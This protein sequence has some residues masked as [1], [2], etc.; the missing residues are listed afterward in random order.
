[1]SNSER[2]HPLVLQAQDKLAA[3]RIDR[4]E[5]LRYATLL[6]TSLTAA[7]VLAACGQPAAAPAAAPATEPAAAAADAPAAAE[8]PAAPAGP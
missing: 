7:T 5:F 2:I 8:A 6:G 3:G 1:M 4:R